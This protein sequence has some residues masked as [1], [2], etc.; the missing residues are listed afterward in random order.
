MRQA[1][2]L[3]DQAGLGPEQYALYVDYPYFHLCHGLGLNSSELPLVRLTD[4]TVI[5]AG[6]VF[7]VEAYVR[8]PDMQYGSEEDVLVTTS[9]CET[10][11]E[12]DA[13]LYVIA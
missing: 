12:I 5:E 2:R 4:T 13:G 10:L 3:Y 8:G 6:M 9:G 1:F 7:S 11:S